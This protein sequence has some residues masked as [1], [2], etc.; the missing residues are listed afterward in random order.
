M[1]KIAFHFCE[2][3]F[4]FTTQTKDLNSGRLIVLPSCI[5]SGS[6]SIPAWIRK[7]HFLGIYQLMKHYIQWGI[8]LHFV[9]VIRRN[10]INV[11]FSGNHWIMSDS[12]ILINQLLI[13][14]NYTQKMWKNNCRSKAKQFLQTVSTQVFNQQ[15]GV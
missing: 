9:S 8:R 11:D 4:T 15:V 1:S 12:P 10:R 7:Q 6:Y 3:V 14:Q 5:T 2:A 13:F